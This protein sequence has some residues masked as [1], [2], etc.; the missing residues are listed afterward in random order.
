MR[1]VIILAL[2]AC[3][4]AASAC[5][6]S[7]APDHVLDLWPDGIAPGS[8]AI[9]ASLREAEVERS[10]R[11]DQI[12]DRYLTGITRPRLLVFTPANP[13]GA[14][15]LV[16]PGGGYQRVVLDKE[17]IESAEWFA[18]AGFTVFVLLYRLPHEGHSMPA[19]TPFMDGQRA[20]RVARSLA[21]DYGF[22]P[23]RV[24]VLG[25]SAGGHLA[26]SLATGFDR[27]IQPARDRIDRISARPDFAVL[28]YPVTRMTGPAVHPGSRAR[29]LGDSP[30]EAQLRIYDL[31]QQARADAP[32]SFLFHA[33]DDSAVLLENSR[34]LHDA[35]VSVGADTQLHVYASGGHGFGLRGTAGQPTQDWPDRV[36]SWL[37]SRGMVD[38][39]RRP[40]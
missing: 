6:P 1:P 39:A 38:A 15:L 20:L 4:Q 25:F 35:L 21:G 29:L 24:G 8:A 18:E 11:P 27:Q 30:D 40:D 28:A 2:I 31:P 36:L 10:A 34:A 14:A 12:R 3:V 37:V 16:I 13:N 26:A 9:A 5:A 17:G 22:D 32:P 19:D 7:R 23:D 33:A